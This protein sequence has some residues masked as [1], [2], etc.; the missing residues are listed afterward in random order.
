MA[1]SAPAT[2]TLTID[3]VLDAPVTVADSYSLSQDT[4]FFVPVMMNDSDPDSNTLTLT[5]YT[6]P[7]NGVLVVSGTGFNYTPNTGYIG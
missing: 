1:S 6:N 4:T 2:V 7:T 3:P 5:G